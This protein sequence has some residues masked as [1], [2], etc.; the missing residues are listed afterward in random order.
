[1]KVVPS[2]YH[3]VIKFL[4]KWRVRSIKGEQKAY[5]ACY[6]N[7]IK[8]KS[9]HE[10]ELWQLQKLDDREALPRMEDMDDISIDRSHR[11]IKV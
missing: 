9:T 2:L 6:R 3:Q 11:E 7:L 5:K 8:Y 4:T 1:M 10:S